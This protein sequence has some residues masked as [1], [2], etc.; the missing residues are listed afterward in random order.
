ME[1]WVPLSK[2]DGGIGLDDRIAVIDQEAHVL[3][4]PAV[5]TCQVCGA[6]FYKCAPWHIN[7]SRDCRWRWHRRR[8]ALWFWA[9][10]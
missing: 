4:N 5:N 6:E 7:C 8:V 10:T 9:H 3:A 2:H 1:K